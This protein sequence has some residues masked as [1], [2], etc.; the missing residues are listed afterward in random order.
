MSNSQGVLRFLFLSVIWLM[1]VHSAC[2]KKDLLMEKQVTGTILQL[3]VPH[4]Q[5]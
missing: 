3:H 1:F 5:Q 2:I 4:E